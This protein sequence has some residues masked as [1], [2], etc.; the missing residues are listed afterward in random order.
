MTTPYTRP[1][2]RPAKP[3]TREEI[4]AYV[5][6]RYVVPTPKCFNGGMCVYTDANGVCGCVVGGMLTAEDAAAFGVG[7]VSRV[8]EENRSAFLAYFSLSDVEFLRKLQGKHDSGV[9]PLT[10][11]NFSPILEEYKL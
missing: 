11:S 9:S 1:K 7:G 8:S 2:S 6:E 5:R 3:Y 4:A 10:L